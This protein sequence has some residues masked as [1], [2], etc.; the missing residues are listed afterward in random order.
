MDLKLTQADLETLGKPNGTAQTTPPPRH[1][2]GEYF[3]KGP[4]P[5]SWLAPASR[6]PGRALHVATAI[7]FLAGVGRT[8]TIRLQ[9]GLL[10][11]LGVNRH[12]AY[13]GLNALEE[14]GLVAVERRPGGN[15]KVTI[16]DQ[17]G[18]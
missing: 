11:Q 1:R 14:A 2:P 6:L 8:R 17:S 4:I 12:A 3:L 5:L 10:R 16:L 15:P 13:R 9:G 18:D 7:W